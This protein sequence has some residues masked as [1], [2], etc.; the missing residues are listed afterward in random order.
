MRNG[1]RWIPAIVLTLGAVLNL[2]LVARRAGTTPLIGNLAT[3]ADTVM[4]VAGVDVEVGEDEKRVAGFTDYMLRQYTMADGQT[5]GLY[6]G[7]YDEQRQGKSIHSPRNCLPGGGW[8]PVSQ[9]VVTIPTTIYGD[10]DINRYEIVKEQSRAIVYYWYQGRGRVEQNEYTVKFQLLRDAA[11]H[12]RTEEA[13]VRIV[14]PVVKDDVAAADK[15]ALEIATP[16][17]ADVDRVLPRL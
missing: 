4:G 11:L 17:V 5:F 10:V 8:D 9:R 1:H 12:G 6:V 7:Y 16:L 14:V 15:L 3:V 2:S 13:L